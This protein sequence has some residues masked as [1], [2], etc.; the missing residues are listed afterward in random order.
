MAMTEFEELLIDPDLR[1]LIELQRTG[2]EALDVI[3]SLEIQH[4]RFL[5]WMF[6][7][8]EGHGQGEE[9]FRDLLLHAS[10]RSRQGNAASSLKGSTRRFFDLHP[11]ARIHSMSLGSAFV[12]RELKVSDHSQLDLFIVDDQNRF[13]L[14][15]ENKVGAKVHDPQ[16]FQYRSELHSLVSR[17]TQ[18]WEVALICLDKNHEPDEKEPGSRD[19]GNW[20][21][22]DYSWLAQT[23]KRAEMQV[24]RGN[25]SAALVAAYCN[26]Q[27]EDWESPSQR[28]SQELA[29]RLYMAHRDEVAKL[30][31]IRPKIA[32]LAW[33]LGSSSRE[34]ELFALQHRGA[35]DQL[36]GVNAFS[37][38]EILVQKAI[39]SLPRR[40]TWADATSLDICPNSWETIERRDDEGESWKALQFRIVF[41]TGEPNHFT[42]RIVWFHEN[43]MLNADSL[44]LMLTEAFSDTAVVWRGNYKAGVEYLDSFEVA[45]G[46][47]SSRLIA[48]VKVWNVRLSTALADAP[49][50]W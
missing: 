27:L 39:P 29:A 5:A 44:A 35:V 25:A 7:S 22:L 19:E 17:S 42:L 4:S 10:V 30:V 36:R 26:R 14:V 13:V 28:R 41:S 1:E 32:A 38:L 6:D 3:K 20:L 43:A 8:R 47:T 34:R 16:L 37:A 23:A 24:Q 46:L 11:P 9:I 48:L 2:T 21:L 40:S 49:F 12:V 31:A 18:D 15:I 33:I 50:D 45:S